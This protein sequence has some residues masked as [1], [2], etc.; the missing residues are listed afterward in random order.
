LRHRFIGGPRGRVLIRHGA[1]MALT[2]GDEKWKFL[3]SSFQKT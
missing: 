1:S 3:T 2:I